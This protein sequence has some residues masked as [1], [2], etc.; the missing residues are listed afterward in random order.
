M[1]ICES[2]EACISICMCAKSSIRHMSRPIPSTVLSLVNLTTDVPL[3]WS[4]P[5]W[6]P[7]RGGGAG[8]GYP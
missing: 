3:Q 5:V 8:S 2:M 7:G 1:L 4:I 6:V